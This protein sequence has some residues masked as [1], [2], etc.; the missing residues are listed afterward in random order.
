MWEISLTSK[1]ISDV[2]SS[3]GFTIVYGSGAKMGS[4]YGDMAITVST[5]TMRRLGG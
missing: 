2:R 4:E 1:A 3:Y 5:S